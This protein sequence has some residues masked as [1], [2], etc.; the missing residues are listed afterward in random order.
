MTNFGGKK[1]KSFAL[2]IAILSL[3]ALSH[4]QNSYGKTPDSQT[5]NKAKHILPQPDGKTDDDDDVNT[6]DET[7]N[8]SD[9]TPV[10]RPRVPTPPPSPQ[11]A[12]YCVTQQG[13]APMVVQGVPVGSPCY[14]PLVVP[15]PYGPRRVNLPGVAR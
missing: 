9:V 1:M 5:V 15:T 10:P 2:A 8:G 12:T 3:T 11:Y 4:A 7:T 14:V 13:A 6:D